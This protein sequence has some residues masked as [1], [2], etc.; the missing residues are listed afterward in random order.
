MARYKELLEKG[1]SNKKNFL[2]MREKQI[3]DNV[4]LTQEEKSKRK[5][6]LNSNRLSLLKQAREKVSTATDACLL[7]GEGPLRAR[8]P[9]DR[10]VPR[11]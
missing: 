3:K 8:A 7:A 2:E 5:A 9:Q 11:A 6:R 10:E 1:D 4:R